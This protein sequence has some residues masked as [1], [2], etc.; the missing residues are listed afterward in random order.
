MDKTNSN[1]NFNS[2][3]SNNKANS[4]TNTLSK[5][6]KISLDNKN[7]QQLY[8][9]TKLKNNYVSNYSGFDGNNISKQ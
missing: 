6:K 1:V 9:L 4:F 8:N 2:S 5:A 3:Q 7:K